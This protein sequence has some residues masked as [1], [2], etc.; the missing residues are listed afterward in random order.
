MSRKILIGNGILITRDEKSRF[1]DKGAVCIEGERVLE[2][3]DHALLLRKYQDAE[4]IDAEGML[5]MPGFIN[6]HQHIYS[7]FSRGMA[8]SGKTPMTFLEILDGIWWHIDRNLALDE[9]Y[10]SAIACGIECIRN[11]VTFISDHHA[12]FGGITGSLGRIADALKLLGLRACLAYE[13]SDRDGLDKR[14]ASVAENMDFIER[15]HQEN[16]NMLKGLVGL[17]ASFTL[18]DET[19]DMCLQKN[20]HGAGY[21]VHVAEGLYDEEHCEKTYGKSVVKRLIDKGILNRESFAVHCSHVSR[22][23]MDLL[24]ENGVTVIHNPES[25]MGNAVGAPDII[26]MMDKGIRVGLG[27]DGYTNDMMESLKVANILQKHNRKLPDRG[28]AEAAKMCFENNAIIA[29]EIIGEKY[30]AI[31]AGRPAD[32]ILV[33]YHP[34]TPLNK[35]NIDGHLM[36]GVSGSMTDT[37]IINGKVIMRHRKLVNVDEEQ[38]LAEGR[39]AASRLWMKL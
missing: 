17:H 18:S 10:Y 19:L 24:A 27:T 38:L 15:V 34:V 33:D 32:V 3:G 31:E 39:E 36:F 30:G 14:D 22:D 5:I 2:A 26:T 8:L 21:H 37:T 35:D 25:N 28:F 9:T 4:Y 11:G 23:D 13:V 6:T 7:E 16:S 12:S 20:V 29:S 1:F